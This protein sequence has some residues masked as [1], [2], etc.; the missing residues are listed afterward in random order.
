MQ[1]CAHTLEHTHDH[2]GTNVFHVCVEFTFNGA[3]VICSQDLERL[4]RGNQTMVGTGNEWLYEQQRPLLSA[5]VQPHT[6]SCSE[7]QE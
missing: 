2:T 4:S 5:E 7:R 3:S 1:M 6:L